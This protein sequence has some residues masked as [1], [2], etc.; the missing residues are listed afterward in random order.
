MFEELIRLIRENKYTEVKES[1]AKV[2]SEKLEE[3]LYLAAK[4][5]YSKLVDVL[6]ENNIKLIFIDDSGKNALHCAI[7][8]K[9]NKV[10]EKLI[11][12]GISVSQIDKKGN[13]PL[14]Y[15]AAAGNL[16]L[17]QK[18]IKADSG[19]YLKTNN[20]GST[21]LDLAEEHNKVIKLLK[22]NHNNLIKNN[23]S[24]LD[25]K[26]KVE[27]DKITVLAKE[28]NNANV[29]DELIKA[30]TFPEDKNQIEKLI[31]LGANPFKWDEFGNSAFSTSLLNN[32]QA[33]AKYYLS[34]KFPEKWQFIEKEINNDEKAFCKYIASHI[35][36]KDSELRDLLGYNTQAA[37]ICFAEAS[38]YYDV[39]GEDSS[40]LFAY[41][42]L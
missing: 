4:K 29:I 5:G 14:H 40:N 28:L 20:E 25:K 12:K 6:L 42:E 13:T 1:I 31:K 41:Y 3:F 26:E 22:E 32:N 15:A 24:S 8:H 33:I 35:A 18:I 9:Y 30:T 16:F 36:T 39:I 11:D 27:I 2:D 10:A 17:V 23:Q 34:S 21:A 7:K 19:I 37:K 38:S